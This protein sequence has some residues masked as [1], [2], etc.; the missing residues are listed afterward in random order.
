MPESASCVT[1]TCMSKNVTLRVVNVL[2]EPRFAMSLQLPST[3]EKYLLGIMQEAA[4]KNS[5]FRCG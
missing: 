1:C 3:H 5:S 4:D 2:K